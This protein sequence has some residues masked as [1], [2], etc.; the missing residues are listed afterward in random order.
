MSETNPYDVTEEQQGPPFPP[1]NSAA[2]ESPERIGRYRIEKVL[3]R[4]GFGLVYLV[5]DERLDR[6]MA[7]KVPHAKLITRPEDA[8]EYLA[9]ART[10]ANLDHP[11]IVPV[12]DVGSTPDCPCYIVSKYIEGTDLSTKLKQQRLRYLEAVEL[13]APVAEASVTTTNDDDSL[14]A[15]SVWHRPRVPFAANDALGKEQAEAAVALLKM[16]EGERV[17][18]LLEHAPEPGR[19]SHLMRLLSARGVNPRTLIERLEIEK[20]DSIRRALILALG[21]FSDQQLP[22]AARELLAAQLLEV[23]STDS[24]AGIH[25]AS[26]WVLR[27]WGKLEEL[28]Q[29]TIELATDQPVGEM[30]WFINRQGQALTVIAGPSEF[31]M[32]SPVEA[33]GREGGPGGKMEMQH[34]ERINR[35]YAIMSHEVTVDQYLKFRPDFDYSK[36]YAREGDAPITRISWYAAAEYCNWLSQQESIP[37]DQWCYSPNDDGE[38]GVGMKPAPDY[39]ERRGYRLPTEAEWEFACAAGADKLL[40]RRS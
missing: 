31:L 13:V 17:W 22:S 23:F 27:R 18:P 2:A 39:L 32:G 3:G 25:A 24:D 4:G 40:L 26:E 7:V 38:Y 30:Q 11:G 1:D 8:A 28:K 12:H 21:E 35:T 36:Q 33:V 20:E 29:R 34:H 6:P 16:N 9:E 10:V 15:A 5:H 14:L 37:E 19:R